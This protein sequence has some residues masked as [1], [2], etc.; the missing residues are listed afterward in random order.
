MPET[1]D[2]TMPFDF[3][4]PIDR[5]GTYSEKWERYAGSEIIPLWVADMDFRSPPAILQ[6]L[7]DRIDHGVLGYTAVPQPLIEVFCQ[8]VRDSYHWDISP[9]W[10][11]FIPGLVCGLNITA[12]AVGQPGDSVLTATPVYP[13][14]FS[15]PKN[16]GRQVLRVPLARTGG[17]WQLDFEAFE[18]AVQPDTRLFLLCNPHNPVGRCFDKDEL[19][20]V[21][22]FC[23]RHDLVICADEIH[24][25]LVLSPDKQHIP[26]ASLDPE[27]ARR[28]ITLMA[29]SKTYNIPGLGASVAIISNPELRVRFRRAMA[30]I[31][32][33]VN[34]LGLVAALAAYQDCRAWRDELLAYLRGNRDL[35][36]RE[37]SG[38]PGLSISP[39]EGTYLSWIDARGLGVEHPATFF[40]KAGVGLSDGIPFDGAG[41]VRLNFGCPRPLLVKALARMKSAVAK[42]RG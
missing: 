14:F 24:N 26:I 41:F 39:V 15:G 3:D 28:T 38:I 6:A 30:G 8:Y 29:P 22:K 36:D 19:L 13:P 10:V 25:E 40:E 4:T 31:V 1:K 33:H 9:D 11:V 21:A 27:I 34:V 20:G 23:D 12:A 42:L 32:P 35:V 37:I 7:H 18:R 17:R 5:K 2:Q 16:M